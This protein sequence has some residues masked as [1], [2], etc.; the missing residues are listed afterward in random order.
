MSL[1]GASGDGDGDSDDEVKKTEG[2]LPLLMISPALPFYYPFLF[3]VWFLDLDKTE[4][5]GNN[6]LFILLFPFAFLSCLRLDF[7]I[8]FSKQRGDNF[9]FVLPFSFFFLFF[10]FFRKKKKR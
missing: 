8:L 6:L 7:F 5:K 1:S 2:Y 3:P 9:F 10:C 4:D